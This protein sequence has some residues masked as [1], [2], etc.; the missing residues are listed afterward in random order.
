MGLVPSTVCYYC[1][2]GCSAQVVCARRSRLAEGV[3]AGAGSCFSP[4]APPC[5]RVPRGACSELSRPGV[6]SLCLP[7]RHSMLSVRPAGSVQLPFGSAPRVRCVCV[8]SCSRGVRPPPFTGLVWRAHYA[9]IPVQGAGR[10]VPGGLCPSAFP[11]PVPCC[12]YLALW[13]VARSVRPLALLGAAGA[14]AGRPA[15]VSW[16]CALWGL[17]ERAQGGRLSP[18]C[19]APG[20]GR[21]PRPTFRPRGVQA[22]PATH[23]LWVRV[24]LAW[25]PVAI[26]TARALAS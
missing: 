24:L 25:G 9:P 12:A 1:L 6:P 19:G 20:V 13:G 5:P 17:H 4:W 16:L 23:W 15:F 10:A 21:S 2:G 7:V 18:G 14:P 11:S 26:S 22:G 3:G 8:C